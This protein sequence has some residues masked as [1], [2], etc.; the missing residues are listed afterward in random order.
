MTYG[1]SQINSYPVN[2][3]RQGTQAGQVAPLQ[4]AEITPGSMADVSL[5]QAVR[6]NLGRLI[7]PEV[8]R[9]FSPDDIHIEAS[10]DGR[11]VEIKAENSQY[12]FSLELAEFR[13]RGVRQDIVISGL[14]CQSKGAYRRLGGME[15]IR[16]NLPG[17]LSGLGYRRLSMQLIADSYSQRM[18]PVLAEMGAEV[19]HIGDHIIINIEVE[20]L[21]DTPS[22]GA[23]QVRR[24][25]ATESF[26]FAEP[27]QVVSMPEQRP[28]VEVV[29]LPPL[30]IDDVNPLL[31]VEIPSGQTRTVTFL[32]QDGQGNPTIVTAELTAITE[33]NGDPQIYIRLN[34]NDFPTFI[35][36]DSPTYY[37]KDGI[38]LQRQGN[39]IV[40]MQVDA[41]PSAVGGI[42]QANGEVQ[43][44]Y[45]GSR[46]D[47]PTIVTAD[48]KVAQEIVY[49]DAKYTLTTTAQEIT[50]T[51]HGPRGQDTAIQ[52]GRLGPF[53]IQ[54]NRVYFSPFHLQDGT[55]EAYAPDYSPQ[56][57][58]LQ[59]A[60]L[61][62]LETIIQPA[63]TQATEDAGFAAQLEQG[64]FSLLTPEVAQYFQGPGAA[65]DGVATTFERRQS[66][67]GSEYYVFK[68][69]NDMV[70]PTAEGLR[71]RYSFCIVLKPTRDALGNI[72]SLEVAGIRLRDHVRVAAALAEGRSA[73]DPQLG[74]TGPGGT[75]DMFVGL[76]NLAR[77]A[78]VES[79]KLVPDGGELFRYYSGV[80]ERLNLPFEMNGP[81]MQVRVPEAEVRLPETAVPEVAPVPQ[82]A[83]LTPE[84]M[85]DTQNPTLSL[86]VR[87]EQPRVFGIP[88]VDSEGNSYTVNAELSAM[89]DFSGNRLIFVRYEGFEANP[90]KLVEGEP[91]IFGDILYQRVGD[92]VMV[93][94]IGGY[95]AT[96]N[97]SYPDGTTASYVPGQLAVLT[98]L[99]VGDA[100][101]TINVTYNGTQ[102]TAVSDSNGTSLTYR[103]PNGQEITV[104]DGRLGPFTVSRE[105]IRLSP[106][107][108]QDGQIYAY[109][110]DYV[111][112][113]A[114]QAV[115]NFA[116]APSGVILT[117]SLPDGYYE[118]MRMLDERFGRDVTGIIEGKIAGQ[119]NVNFDRLRQ[120]LVKFRQT[121]Q[122]TP[123]LAALNLSAS[124][125]GRLEVEL[126]AAH[127][128]YVSG[129]AYHFNELQTKLADPNSRFTAAEIEQEQLALQAMAE[130]SD[131]VAMIGQERITA[132]QQSL[133]A[134]AGE[135]AQT[136]A[137]TETTSAVG[138]S[139]TDVLV[140]EYGLTTA[141]AAQVVTLMTTPGITEQL[142]TAKLQEISP[143]MAGNVGKL[144][145]RVT[146]I[147]TE[148]IAAAAQAN[149]ALAQ[150]L[151]EQFQVSG[152]SIGSEI[153]QEICQEYVQGG[154][155]GALGTNAPI[156]GFLLEPLVEPEMLAALARGRFGA[157]RGFFSTGM[158]GTGAGIVGN[159]VYNMLLA[160][161][162]VGDD[163]LARG[164]VP[165]VTAGVFST[166][167]YT[168]L[169][170]GA[171]TANSAFGRAL[172]RLM[173]NP[174]TQRLLV[175][176]ALNAPITDGM[177]RLWG[178]RERMDFYSGAF[179][180]A[181]PAAFG[182]LSLLG[183][184]YATMIIDIFSD[185]DD[186]AVD[187]LIDQS[188]QAEMTGRQVL[189]VLSAIALKYIA[190]NPI[191]LNGDL[192]GDTPLTVTADNA[193]HDA[194]AYYEK[195]VAYNMGT[196][197][198]P[199]SFDP[200][201]IGEAADPL[202]LTGNNPRDLDEVAYTML[203]GL[204]QG[205]DL[206][207]EKPFY[208]ALGLMDN[209]GNPVLTN[210]HVTHGQALFDSRDAVTERNGL[211]LTLGREVHNGAVGEAV[212]FAQDTAR[213]A[214]SA[215]END[216]VTG[217]GVD[218]PTELLGDS[219]GRIDDADLMRYV[220]AENGEAIAD[221][222]QMQRRAYDALQLV[223]RA[224]AGEDV[225]LDY[226]DPFIQAALQQ[227]A[228]MAPAAVI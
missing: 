108:L 105:G 197:T 199:L 220:L 212:D 42:R 50:V 194:P 85:L 87:P 96:A 104:S 205:R 135:T 148:R 31:S 92:T 97:I 114:G 103:G 98:P 13:E 122:I 12:I 150:H 132:A 45:P 107:Y 14:T 203:V 69:S 86:D 191:F 142:F 125:L 134:R 192:Y 190:Q 176:L 91:Q 175:A 36:E 74:G 99:R 225:V 25:P 112:S 158:V 117:M 57:P 39:T 187:A 66:E 151:Q 71:G 157:L 221:I 180:A 110:A 193:Q 5:E 124:E 136:A 54:D 24:T 211:V 184:E 147:V 213:Q 223:S 165:Q 195:L 129:R 201:L 59:G 138:R 121:G 8:Y 126:Q 177:T 162:G 58:S 146:E 62:D 159:N 227:L 118:G 222:S 9:S 51:Y 65:G 111:P 186:E 208:Q 128:E 7:P 84:I 38:V 140:S 17:L 153:M 20:K 11:H 101:R 219:R 115:V 76:F 127:T 131:L 167:L 202:E 40:A 67:T 37:G 43:F 33:T 179:D 172:G 90:Y 93:H 102:Y 29:E 72:V 210:E 48:D 217:I 35:R 77:Q 145:A 188:V 181:H 171:T 204:H 123:S 68:S 119:P 161:A 34:E 26:S 16:A 185:A 2:Q 75:P 215:V 200:S 10:L 133:A 78:G 64:R 130:Q 6:D 47:L 73:V 56:A 27:D 23:G 30:V 109:Q 61:I 19:R 196:T 95:Q 170:S 209:N 183:S 224:L 3:A 113:S 174:I 1:S 141:Q 53:V 88:A 70:E 81:F 182:A 169:A 18:A 139:I 206:S 28:Q 178:E 79:I 149:P 226:S 55:I 155:T 160:L 100:A 144:K 21:L 83:V 89:T 106:Y 207:A 168:Q 154:I 164:L 44:L 189:D 49:G 60:E 216:I 80:F 173:S 198:N 15:H 32:A 120:A 137:A 82:P 116:G 4:F 63:P 94:R 46:I 22:V 163:S 214:R 218:L 52:N 152:G 156:V 166:M 41:M 228:S 143:E